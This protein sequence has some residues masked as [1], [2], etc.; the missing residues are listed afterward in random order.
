VLTRAAGGLGLGLSISRSIAE[1]HGGHLAAASGGKN[2][3][4]T[5]ALK[6]PS[7]DGPPRETRPAET[8]RQHMTA[9]GGHPALVT[10]VGQ[11]DTR[12]T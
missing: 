12:V 1:Q 4:A 2:L 10:R 8:L 6:M 9:T 11:R 7:F 3:G 5:F